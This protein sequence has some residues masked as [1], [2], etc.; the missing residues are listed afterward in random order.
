MLTFLSDERII[1]DD[2]QSLYSLADSNIKY[3]PDGTLVATSNGHTL[4]IWD[5]LARTLIYDVN[6]EISDF[7]FSADGKIMA[8]VDS[9]NKVTLW[10][11]N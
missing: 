7:A 11:I 1:F 6:L 2:T 8:T 3:T 10:G 5:I 4:Y 9:D